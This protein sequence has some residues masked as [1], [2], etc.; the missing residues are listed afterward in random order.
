MNFI[1]KGTTCI[2]FKNFIIFTNISVED[3]VKIIG[4]VKKEQCTG[5]SFIC[6]NLLLVSIFYL[7]T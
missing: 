3:K 4:R 2:K 7:Q 1:Y 5:M 6:Y